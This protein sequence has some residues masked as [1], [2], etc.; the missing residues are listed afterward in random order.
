MYRTA[1][2]RN[3]IV[4]L[5]AIGAI[6]LMSIWQPTMSGVG[7]VLAAGPQAP[8]AQTTNFTWS[9]TSSSVTTQ[10]G[11]TINVSTFRLT[12][13]TGGSASFAISLSNV[14]AG[15]TVNI[16]PSSA[17]T[18]ADGV[19]QAFTFQIIIPASTTPAQY[20]LTVNATRTDITGLNPSVAFLTVTVTLPPTN[21]PTP[22]TT[23]TPSP[24]VGPT[25]T[26]TPVCVGSSEANDPGNDMASAQL[27]LVDVLEKHGICQIGDLDWFKFGGVAGKIY[28]ID[29]PQ[30][31]LGLDLSIEL[32]DEQG[33]RLT[34]NDDFFLRNSA[35]PEPK[36]IKPRIQSWRAP[37]NGMYYFL[38]R[39]TLNIGGGGRGYSII[40]NSESYGPTPVTIPEICH[41]LFEDDGLPE[42]AH[43]MTSNE[44]QPAHLLCPRGDADWIRF[45]GSAGKTYYLYTDTRPYANKP[46]INS[47]TEAGADT[48]L[49]LAD[50]DGVSI[51]DFNDDIQ[52]GGSLDSELRFT[53]TVDGF[54][55]AQVKNV[56]DIGNQ[57]IHY[58]LVL[59]LCVPNQECGRSPVTGSGSGSDSSAPTAASDS[60][61]SDQ[62]GAQTPTT[63][64]AGFIPNTLKPG[65]MVN[66]PIQGFADS[67][68][69]QVWR[70]NDQ[71][72]AEQRTVRSW[73][74]GPHG[75]MARTEG[76]LQSA[77]GL[78]QVQYFDKARM[79]V[80]NPNGDRKSPWFVTTGLL[81]V[82]L[83][84]GNAQIGD[85]EFVQRGPANIP[86]V[87]DMDDPQAPVYASFAGSLQQSPGDR[88]GQIVAE[89]IDRAGVIGGY[90]GPQRSETRL[91]QFIPNTGHNIPQIF[92]DYLN[93]RGTIADG[94]RYRDD[95]LIN[96][97]FTLGYP[98]SEPYWTRVR[99][100]GVERDVLVQA[101]QRRVL[102]Y[103]PDNPRGWQV[104]MGNV[105]RHYYL[106]R[107]GQNLPDE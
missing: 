13:N 19:S 4:T 72:L 88:T 28:T 42:Q 56:G 66:G 69:E 64:S 81:V 68:F 90:A 9:P 97:V 35:T 26:P 65:P 48:V 23:P 32:Y 20:N 33:N 105:G 53:P 91:T 107:Y 6:L 11:T 24:T 3:L 1:Q 38:V 2:I 5:G 77:S 51:I 74:W 7:T 34:S 100:G 98:I 12:N 30:M 75:L 86:I 29:V 16:A 41:D 106:W 73:A 57:F 102:T 61:S 47:Q 27:I 71:P 95:V 25:S 36:D 15:W 85:N 55:Y 83:I 49:Y 79:E 31:D 46:D 70:R 63:T 22:T 94:G 14:P 17:V 96:W 89:S 54:Y 62:G 78:R 8:M 39:D 101:F 103:S 21:T 50:R 82:E 99:V 92:W 104:E 59:K 45:F 44:V 76:Y 18:L 80:N 43:L 60:G 52:G 67:A 87:G 10:Q 84:S 58:D 37:R 40:V 93:A